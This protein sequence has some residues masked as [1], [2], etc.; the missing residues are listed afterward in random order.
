LKTSNIFEG[1]D[2]ILH[3][4]VYPFAKN[5]AKNEG[6]FLEFRQQNF[7]FAADDDVL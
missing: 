5:Q 4:G 7:L 2:V 6:D 3:E 1:H